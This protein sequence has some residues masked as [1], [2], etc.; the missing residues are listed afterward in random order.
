[1]TDARAVE[2]LTALRDVGRLGAPMGVCVHLAAAPPETQALVRS[3]FAQHPRLVT[4]DGPV[5]EALSGALLL[6]LGE[7]AARE[8]RRVRR[9]LRRVPAG[10]GRA[11]A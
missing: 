4:G 2:L 3:L 1:M 8:L 7:R 9:R 5:P 6:E 10:R 11:H